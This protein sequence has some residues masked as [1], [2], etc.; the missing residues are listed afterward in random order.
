MPASNRMPA[1]RWK[2]G[3][4]VRRFVGTVILVAGA[5]AIAADLR[6]MAIPGLG[7]PQLPDA[8]SMALK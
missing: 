7:Q 3:T 4:A 8:A 6:A 2:Y 5:A 1:R